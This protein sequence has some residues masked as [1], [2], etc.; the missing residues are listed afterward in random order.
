MPRN[1][2]GVGG[3]S[4]WENMWFGGRNLNIKKTFAEQREL[5]KERSSPSRVSY[6]AWLRCE[7][8]S[9]RSYGGR[10]G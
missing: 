2:W 5:L 6:F 1:A 8:W 7:R 9:Q 10:G 3:K 4:G